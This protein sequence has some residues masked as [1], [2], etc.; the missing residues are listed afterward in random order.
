L[1]LTG[2]F[3]VADAEGFEGGGVAVADV[4]R[5]L[6][7]EGLHRPRPQRAAAGQFHRFHRRARAA[8]AASLGREGVG[9]AV[10]AA[11]AEQVR[12]VALTEGPGEDAL[13]D[14]YLCRHEASSRSVQSVMYGDSN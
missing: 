11:A 8:R 12:L 6:R 7:R 10:R 13:L 3:D 4:R 14:R 2:Q 5:G 1:D 9:A